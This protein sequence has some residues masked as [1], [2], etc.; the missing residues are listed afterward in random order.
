V[1]GMRFRV[2][3]QGGSA[4]TPTWRFV[5]ALT[6]GTVFHLALRQT[7]GF[8]LIGLMGLALKAAPSHD[9]VSLWRSGPVLAMVAI[10]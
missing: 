1:H 2:V 7:E 8:V 4:D 3:V 10:D 5:T 6:L 9:R